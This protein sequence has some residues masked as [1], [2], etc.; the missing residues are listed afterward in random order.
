MPTICDGNQCK[1]GEGGDRKGGEVPTGVK[2]PKA[3]NGT[4]IDM[5]PERPEGCAEIVA[6]CREGVHE[7]IRKRRGVERGGILSCHMGL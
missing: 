7:T 3:G 1:G 2:R 5:E 4:A 6:D